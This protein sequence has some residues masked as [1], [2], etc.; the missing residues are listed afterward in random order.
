[1]PAVSFVVPCHRL[2][3]LLPDCL[4]SILAQS[5]S[6][7]EILVMD[8]CSPDDTPEV[9]RSFADPRVQH[10]RHAANL[11]HIRNYNDGVSR[12]RGRYIWLIS[13][14]DVIRRSDA[15]ERYVALL[16]AHPEVGFVCCP[17]IEMI[18]GVEREVAS[19]SDR[20]PRDRVFPGRQFLREYLLRGNS[21]PAASGLVRAQCYR[22]LGLFPADL[23]FAADW[24]MWSA[25]AIHYDVAY[26]ADPLV[27]Y[28]LHEASMTEGFI[29]GDPGPCS[30]DDIAMPWTMLRMLQEKGE[31]ELERDCLEA[32]AF[33]YGRQLAGRI[34]GG[35]PALSLA[36]F[37]HSLRSLARSE[38]EVRWVRPRAF[39]SAGD[40]MF[41][42]DEIPQARGMYRL[43]LRAGPAMLEV[44]AKYLLLRLA[45]PSLLRLLRRYRRL[46]GLRG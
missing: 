42:R 39:R 29:S 37:E 44:W 36:D 2:A 7:F 30:K 31:S 1:M 40:A 25:I 13:A 32:V 23:P 45:G 15:L 14:D 18:A 17:A 12:A 5:Y 22:K 20:G 10:I 26:L 46:G 43:A 27:C 38:Q 41:G 34:Y 28:R 16:D 35:Y 9:V 8:D 3:H 6:D 24:Y 19:Y 21:V 33:Q 4:R 11:G